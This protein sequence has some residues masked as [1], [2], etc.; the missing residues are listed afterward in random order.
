M[1]KITHKCVLID[2]DGCLVYHRGSLGRQ[3]QTPEPELIQGTIDKL[4]EWDRAGYTIILITGRRES[5]RKKTET[6]LAKLGIFYDQLIM[7]VGRGPRILINDAKPDGL[8]TAHAICLPRNKG[9]KDIEI[10]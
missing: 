9:I 2:I 10:P 3:A 4:D 8:V 6:D 1:Q 7:G 5:M